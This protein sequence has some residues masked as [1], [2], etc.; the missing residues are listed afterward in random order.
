MELALASAARCAQ[1]LQSHLLG[2][3]HRSAPICA[4]VPVVDDDKNMQLYDDKYNYKYRTPVP[5]IVVDTI[6]TVYIVH[7]HTVDLNSSC[8]PPS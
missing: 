8:A 5:C 7:Y 6:H 3:R 4:A 1:C 2:K